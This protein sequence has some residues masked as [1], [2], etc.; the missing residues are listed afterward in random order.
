MAASDGV[1]RKTPTDGPERFDVVR[2]HPLGDDRWV[3]AAEHLREG[4]PSDYHRTGKAPL[5]FFRSVG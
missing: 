2:P 5:F 1:G 4:T 3:V